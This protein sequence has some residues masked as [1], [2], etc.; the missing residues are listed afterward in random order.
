[1]RL[2]IIDDDSEVHHV[3]EDIEEYNLSKP[4]AAAA[5]VERIMIVLEDLSDDKGPVE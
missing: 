5:I 3:A 1:M 4:L 2:V